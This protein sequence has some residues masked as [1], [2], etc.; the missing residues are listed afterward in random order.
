MYAIS[1]MKDVKRL[2][3][4]HGAEHKAIAAYEKGLKMNV[5]NVKEQSRFHPRCGTSFI[6][7]AAIITIIIFSIFDSFYYIFYTYPNILSRIGVHL[8]FLPFAVGISFELLKLSEKYS[9]IGLVK[10]MIQPGLWLQHITTNEPDETQLEV[11]IES[12]MLST[13]Y[14]REKIPA[15]V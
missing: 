13:E 11:A 12:V 1:F 8:L 14:L 7:I 4:Y 6:L 5:E 2:F 3:Q 10:A 9:K 15:E